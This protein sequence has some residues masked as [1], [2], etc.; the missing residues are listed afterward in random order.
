MEINSLIEQLS[1]T[2]KTMSSLLE[3]MSDNHNKLFS[4]HGSQKEQIYSIREGLKTATERISKIITV[5]HEG[6]GQPPL[7]TRVAVLEEKVSENTQDIS[8]LYTRVDSINVSDTALVTERMSHSII[9][10]KVNKE[11]VASIVS[12]LAAIAAAIAAAS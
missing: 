8:K 6:N 9:T 10:K 3:K 5:L 7:V 2:V 4:T 12:A 1:E 11:L